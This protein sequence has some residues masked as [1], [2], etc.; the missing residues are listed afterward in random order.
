MPPSKRRAPADQSRS[1]P[2]RSVRKEPTPSAPEA[3]T[4]PLAGEPRPALSKLLLPALKAHMGDWAYYVVSLRLRDIA[5]RVHIANEI[6]QSTQLRELLQRAL[7]ESRANEI[8]EY[9]LSQP[10]RLFNTMV[11]GAYEGMPEWYEL[12]VGGNEHLSEEELPEYLDG[13]FGILKLSGGERLFALDGQHRLVGI[14]QALADPHA[15]DLGDEEM[16]AIIVAHQP[17]AAGLERTRRLFT[18]LNRYAKP[19]TKREIVALDEDDIVAIVTRRLVESYPLFTGEKSSPTKTSSLPAS[20]RISFVPIVTLYDA[21]DSFLQDRDNWKAFKTRRPEDSV[22][23]D[24]Y[25]RAV[26]LWDALRR[27]IPP[28]DELARAP[29]SAGVPGRYRSSR[30]G[31]LIFRPVGVLLLVRAVRA[32]MRDGRQLE[33]AVRRVAT[34]PMELSRSPW[35]GLIYDPA[36]ERMQTWANQQKVALAILVYGAG[37]SLDAIKTTEARVRTSWA[38]MMNVD[39]PSTLPLKR[40]RGAER[41]GS[42]SS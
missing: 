24:Y 8:R 31:H 14:K 26:L 17:T 11:I 12:N 13:V 30:G 25:K 40:F 32:V 21:L 34:A 16:A 9:L 41:A 18:T 2:R 29:D 10:Q 3:A 39:D 22:I 28:L 36:N 19:V 6:H 33:E 15:G 42:T 23:S 38:G 7:Q 5:A 20:D 1:R 27:R 4:T 37:G 35:A